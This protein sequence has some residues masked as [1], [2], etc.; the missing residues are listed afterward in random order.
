[1]LNSSQR[2]EVST[3]VWKQSTWVCFCAS[4][5]S[6]VAFNVLYVVHH[7][8]ENSF[9]WAPPPAYPSG[10]SAFEPPPPLGISSDPPWIL[11]WIFSGTTNYVT[12][13]TCYAFLNFPFE[14]LPGLLHIIKCMI[15]RDNDPPKYSRM[16]VK[17]LKRFPNLPSDYQWVRFCSR[18]MLFSLVTY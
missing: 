13:K 3:F 10:I 9:P 17:S 5:R 18:K 6:Y 12:T 8:L 16:M 1:M 4:D 2:P 15:A 7:P 11:V 14:L